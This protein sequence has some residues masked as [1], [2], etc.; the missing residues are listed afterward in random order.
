M[1]DKYKIIEY[2][3]PSFPNTP[4]YKVDLDS[5]I[6]HS[7]DLNAVYARRTA[8]IDMKEEYD[9]ATIKSAE[10]MEVYMQDVNY[11]D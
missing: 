5:I 4:Y 11:K 6:Y 8:H 2:C 7:T 9:I 1:V 10:A 3:N